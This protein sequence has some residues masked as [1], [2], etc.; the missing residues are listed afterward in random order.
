MIFHTII[1]LYKK[2][3][4]MV[5]FQKYVVKKKNIGKKIV[6]GGSRFSSTIWSI[7]GFSVSRVL[8]FTARPNQRNF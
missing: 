8:H 5:S 1:G 6:I 2:E 4:I 7:S 3:R